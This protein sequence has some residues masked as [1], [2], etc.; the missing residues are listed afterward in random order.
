MQPFKYDLPPSRPPGPP[1]RK[2]V[3]G[4]IVALSLA[5]VGI[6]AWN[7]SLRGAS[8]GPLGWH[9]G[10]ALHVESR[11][12]GQAFQDAEAHLAKGDAKAAI[13]GFDEA[14]RLDPS[15]IAAWRRGVDARALASD[16]PRPALAVLLPDPG[17]QVTFLLARAAFEADRRPGAAL[18]DLEA[19]LAIA[20]KD[21]RALRARAATLAKAG[22]AP[23][24]IAAYEQGL[25]ILPDDGPLL[26][27]L[28]SLRFHAGRLEQAVE[29]ARTRL[30]PLAKTSR[31][32]AVHLALVQALIEQGQAPDAVKANYAAA[33]PQL[34]ELERRLFLARAY[35]LRYQANPNWNRDAFALAAAE[36]RA[37]LEPKANATPAQR[38]DARDVILEALSAGATRLQAKGDGEGARAAVEQALALRESLI[39]VDPSYKQR[40]ADLYVQRAHLAPVGEPANKLMELALELKPD[41]PVREELVQAYANLGMS[42]AAARKLAMAT[43]PLARAVALK[44]NDPAVM[45]RYYEALASLNTG[46]PLAVCARTAGL[47]RA[48]V[49]TIALAGMERA[50]KAKEAQKLYDNAAKSLL[51][52]D[53]GPA[54]AELLAG[55]GSLAA[56]RGLL[57]QAPPSAGHWRRMAAWDRE[58]AAKAKGAERTAC[59]DRAINAYRHALAL[60]ADDHDRALLL[61]ASR[62]RVELALAAGDAAAAAKGAADALQMDPRNPALN[63]ALA[64]ALDKAADGTGAIAAC[65][66]G[67]KGLAG[68]SD[69]LH[70]PL[71]NRLGG[72]Y[73]VQKRYN[74]AIAEFKAGLDDVAHATPAQAADLYYGLAVAHAANGDREAAINAIRQYVFWSMHDPRQA[75]RVPKLQALELDLTARRSAG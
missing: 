41:H 6:W 50:G 73:Q 45:A 32:P 60:S 62:E 23:G 22:N 27:G 25:R 51:P 20:P 63:L 13:A 18:D 49:L 10:P 16:V 11:N 42:L 65:R 31:D 70:A 52:G 26:A 44:P 36:A 38:Q 15:L 67:L 53:R 54:K 71:R 14:L 43:A 5:L 4:A 7:T 19:A 59:L 9:V 40:F 48:T 24:A 33:T 55:A 8:A 72:L 69:P 12:A 37:V 66:E 17:A 28:V 21:A 1:S 47:D 39:G 35:V 75:A 64:T 2:P 68:P 34:T 61:G 74:E 46:E 58:L 56:A 30:Q 29:E 3:G 57:A